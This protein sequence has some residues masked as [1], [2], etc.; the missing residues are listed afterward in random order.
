MVGKLK[1]LINTDR[2]KGETTFPSLMTNSIMSDKAR[3]NYILKN[4]KNVVVTFNDAEKRNKEVSSIQDAKKS[5]IPT[6]KEAESIDW[7]DSEGNQII[8]Y[9]AKLPHPVSEYSI[10]N[11]LSQ[12]SL[13]VFD[14][15][16]MS[17]QEKEGVA[18]ETEKIKNKQLSVQSI[19]QI[20]YRN[21]LAR[22]TW[23]K[24]IPLLNPWKITLDELSLTLGDYSETTASNAGVLENTPLFNAETSL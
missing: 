12:S 2:L 8:G 5:R 17:F 4:T 7:I 21:V 22:K 9:L 13:K 24:F 10:F 6:Y 23:K 11:V 3:E 20:N 14:S 18:S 16:S 1:S 19:G 15:F